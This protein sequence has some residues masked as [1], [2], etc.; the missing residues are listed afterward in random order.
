MIETKV[1]TCSECGNDIILKIAETIEEYEKLTDND[2]GFITHV[3]IPDLM[4]HVD[5]HVL[6]YKE[7]RWDWDYIETSLSSTRY[8]ADLELLLK[9]DKAKG[10]WHHIPEIKGVSPLD[11]KFD[12]TT[13]KLIV[14]SGITFTPDKRVEKYVVVA[15]E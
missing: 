9:L 7:G 8:E 12:K 13:K 5:C 11:V 10:K 3:G 2:R 4:F 1:G 14:P 15:T 6:M